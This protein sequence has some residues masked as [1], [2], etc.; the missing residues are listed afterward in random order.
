MSKNFELIQQAEYNLKAGASVAT[1][2]PLAQPQTGFRGFQ[3]QAEVVRKDA[4]LNLDKITR[5]ESVRLVQRV[6]LQAGTENPKAVVFAGINHGAG[7]SEIC[8]LAAE[9]LAESISG[10]V[11][12]VEANLRTP[13]LPSIFGTTN[14]HG[15]TDALAKTDSIRNYVKKVRGNNLWLLSS[16][17]ALNGDGIVIGSD[18]NRARLNELRKEFDYLLIDAPPMGE[19]SDAIALGQTADGLVMVLE[20]NSTR[21]EAAARVAE[22][23]RS[24]QVK[25]LG[26]VLNKRTFPIPASLYKVF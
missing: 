20:A 3:T 19:Y 21:R 9:I 13:S 4:G 14:H 1:A 15:L 26:A 17:S 5:E 22:N 2:P 16:G 18:Q 7:C 8:A 10:S 25:I 11:C 24:A 23:L 12:L 6:F